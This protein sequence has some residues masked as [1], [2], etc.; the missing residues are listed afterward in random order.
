MVFRGH[1]YI[2]KVKNWKSTD[3]ITHKPIFE[4]IPKAGEEKPLRE[5]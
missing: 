4:G 5:I 2:P 3:W 1:E